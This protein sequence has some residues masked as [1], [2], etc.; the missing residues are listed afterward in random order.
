[1]LLNYQVKFKWPSRF[2]G[3]EKRPKRSLRRAVPM[4]E[5]T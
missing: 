4:L 1:M 3:M 2:G 5:T